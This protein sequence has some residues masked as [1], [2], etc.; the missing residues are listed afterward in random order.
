MKQAAGT[1]LSWAAGQMVI[2]EKMMAGL[3]DCEQES[4]DAVEHLIG[5]LYGVELNGNGNGN[6][7]GAKEPKPADLY[8][9][10]TLAQTKVMTEA[11]TLSFGFLSGDFNPLH[12]ND[13]QARRSRFNGRIVHGFRTAS[14]FSG[15]L[16]ELCP[17]CVY[18]RQEMEFTA[19]VRAGD[20]I[21]ATG[22]I[23]AIDERGAVTVNLQCV[24]QRGEVVV[25]GQAVLKKLKEIYGQAGAPQS[26]MASV[27]RATTSDERG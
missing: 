13:A 7:H 25:K 23:E 10:K 14:L 9:G 26:S 21:T 3:L 4:P 6:G 16:A 22:V 12:F 20:R 18:L 5:S 2:F 17:W 24:N 19:P 1:V 27:A 8:V 11:G 15:V